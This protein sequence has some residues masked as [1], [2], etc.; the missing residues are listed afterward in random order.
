MKE[1][2]FT[3]R[4]SYFLKKFTNFIE[5]SNNVYNITCASYENI[6]YKSLYFLKK[7]S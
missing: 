7:N 1:L 2:I 3:I 4:V 5:K 6:F